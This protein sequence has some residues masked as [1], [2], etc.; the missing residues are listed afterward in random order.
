[1]TRVL[2]VPALLAGVLLHPAA[3]RPDDIPSYE[4]ATP[5]FG[6]ASAPDASLLIDDAGT[7]VVELRKG[8]GTLIAELPGIVDIAPLGRGSIYAVTG[9]SD[10]AETDDSLLRVS[11]GRINSVADLFAFEAEFNPDGDL[12]ESNPFDVAALSGGR[13]WSPTQRL[14]SVAT[15]PRRRARA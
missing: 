15:G 3:A 2:L 5:I 14:G 7:G 10:G 1:L 11:H 8:K 6:L 12:L 4:F 13:L 9:V